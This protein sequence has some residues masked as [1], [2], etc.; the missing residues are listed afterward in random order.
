MDTLTIVL[1]LIL[2]LVLAVILTDLL[3]LV[4]RWFSRIHIGRWDCNKEWQAASEKKLLAQLKKTPRLP[5]SDQTRLTFIERIKGEYSNATLLQWQQAALLLGANGLCEREKSQREI[6]GF[7]A[8]KIGADGDWQKFVPAP[9]TAMLAFAIL[10]SYAVDKEKCRPAMDR[11][12]ELLFDLAKQSGTIPY[13]NRIPEIRFVD[14]VG[15]IC[16]FLT[17]Y[18][19]EYDCLEALL[20][21]KKQ[22][23]EYAASG[24][25]EK[26]PV[27]VHCF[28]LGSGAP[29]GIYGWGRGC[30]WWAYGLMDSYLTLMHSEMP[31]DDKGCG[32][33]KVVILS[34]EFKTSL[35]DEMT[36]F[37][38]TL[39][40]FQMHSGAWD[41]QVFLMGSGES[42]ATAMLAWFMK[43][44]YRI[45]SE[46]TYIQSYEKA[47]AYLR[48]A[49]RRYG[50]VD[51]A[52]GDTKGIGF[53]C[54]K[55]DAMPAA[56]GFTVRCFVE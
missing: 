21:A 44:M 18:A 41:R 14:T 56:Q 9:E 2:L 52:Q 53:Y 37:A 43:K 1:S 46:E 13:N 27:P 23:D 29:L 39:V 5:L 17:K 45:T 42:S 47:M 8:S 40:A 11:A 19:I 3:P 50:S 7:I 32:N 51:F 33:H 54:A 12:A 36:S 10:S 31:P 38:K 6:E 16:P 48:G 20:L 28:S 4:W 55:L 26:F 25:H 30:G 24:L 34:D 22:I 35:L 49:T 15:M